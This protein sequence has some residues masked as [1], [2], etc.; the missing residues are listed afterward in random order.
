MPLEDGVVLR[1]DANLGLLLD[2]N[3][4]LGRGPRR[5]KGRFSEDL[6]RRLRETAR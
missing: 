5:P 4:E 3:E 6:R 2:E 1:V